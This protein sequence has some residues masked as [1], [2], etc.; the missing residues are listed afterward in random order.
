LITASNQITL[1]TASEVVRIPGKLSVVGDASFNGRVDICGNFYAQYPAASIPSSAIIGGGGSSINLNND[2]SVNGLTIGC[3]TNDIS[4]NSVVG[5]QSLLSNTTGYFN[6]AFGFQALRSNTSGFQNSAFGFQALRSNTSGYVNT[7]NGYQAL[8]TNS[9][10]AA[11]V[12]NGFQ[13]LYSNTIGAQNVATGFHALLNNTTGEYNTANGTF[14]LN[15]NTTGNRNVAYGNRALY[16][17]STG[18]N[19]VANGY[20]AGYNNTTGT[21]NTFLGSGTNISPTNAVW[22]NSTAI[23]ANALITA[24]NQI[25]LGTTTE[26]VRVPGKLSMIGDASFNGRVDIVGN[27]FAVTATAGTNTTQLAT[28]EF[29]T[30]ALSSKAN[31]ASP[32]FTGTPIAP[33]ATAGT[34]TT[35]LATTAFVTTAVSTKAT[36]TLVD[37]SLNLK[38]TTTLVDAS[39][40]LKA[41][42]ANPN[43][44]GNVYISGGTGGNV[45]LNSVYTGKNYI[46]NTPVKIGEDMNVN[47]YGSVVSLNYDG[48][49]IAFGSG[50]VYVYKYN[51]ITGTWTQLGQTISSIGNLAS[52]SLNN[53]GTRIAI[54][55]LLASTNGTSSGAVQVYQYNG[56]TTWTQVGQTVNGEVAQDRFGSS[57]SLSADGNIF[58]AGSIYNSGTGNVRIYQY[59]GSSSWIQIGQSIYGEGSSDWFG[60]SVSLSSNGQILAIGAPYN[61]GTGSQ[62]GHVRVYQYNGSTTWTQLGSDIDGENYSSHSGYSV[63]LSSD[64][65]IVAIGA[66]GNAGNGSQSGSVRVYK[67]ISSTWTQL[68]QDIDGE[69]ASDQSGYA[70][71][72][73]SDGTIV[74][75]GAPYND[76][77]GT[78]SG[79]VRIYQYNGST[80]W[81]QIG[82]DI[83]S[84]GGSYKSGE[85]SIS[86]DGT[87]VAMGSNISLGGSHIYVYKIQAPINKLSINR[88]MEINGLTIGTVNADISTNSVIGYQALNSVTVGYQNSAFG[89]QA[90]LLNT[91]GN[92]NTAIG[93]QAGDLNTTGS[94]NTFLGS[95]ADTSGTTWSSSTAIG[96]N[97]KITASNQITL[98]TASE[99]VRVPGWVSVVGNVTASS[100][101]TSSDYRIKDYVT[102]LSDC[103][104][105]IDKLRPVSYHNKV[106]DKQDIGLIAHEVQ[107]HFPFLVSG[108]KD[109]DE[110]QSVNYTSLIGLLI[111]EIQQLKQ[112]TIPKLNQTIKL[113]EDRVQILETT[114]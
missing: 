6:S 32:S 20:W 49:I 3:G 113:L 94:N 89:Y 56:T 67:Y 96:Y 8:Y 90:L 38:A 44:N 34:N 10:G 73:T 39:L 43:F 71:S 76:G 79:H 100:F 9:D 58:A 47:T 81:I 104:F 35:Q 41:N 98:G 72:L 62:S 5:Y 80:T 50:T 53:D 91:T 112:E 83:N 55:Y 99:V 28:T 30:T 95:L 106:T 16:S 68:G 24:S 14:A 22:A 15:S 84:G 86:K 88:Q 19:N 4:T 45:L 21:F 2:I 69:A 87:T 92:N 110:I 107:E 114:R 40:N 63:S 42:V 36:T 66:P 31:L 51:S 33:T 70:V 57:V 65:T 27:I 25:T 105:T 78:D 61:T 12:A 102:S 7:A 26:V 29:V 101:P 23:G 82:T 37:A 54:G 60:Q 17:N 103:S 74:A 77:N 75:I 59:N 64:G 108:E 111:H 1:G 48:S 52:L 109:G 85:V 13:A 18:N 93:Y 11:N 97:A 46:Y